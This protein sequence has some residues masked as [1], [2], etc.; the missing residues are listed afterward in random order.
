MLAGLRQRLPGLRNKI[1][2]GHL[3]IDPAVFFPEARAHWE[4]RRNDT[5]L[6]ANETSCH[7][8]LTP[9][10]IV[11]NTTAEAP[12]TFRP[13]LDTG[14]PCSSR[15]DQARYYHRRQHAHYVLLPR[16]VQLTRSKTSSP[17]TPKPTSSCTASPA[18]V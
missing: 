16:Y 4:Q 6:V 14:F 5:P 11:F 10:Q 7:A 17:L 8:L 12:S 1:V 2:Q 9:D 15:P 13:F 3:I 18:N